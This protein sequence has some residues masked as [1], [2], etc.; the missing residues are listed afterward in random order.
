MTHQHSKGLTLY[1]IVVIQNSRQLFSIQVIQ[2]MNTMKNE[3]TQQRELI[4]LLQSD[5]N[6]AV[7]ALQNN[8]VDVTRLFAD[9]DN[10]DDGDVPVKGLLGL[11][12][13]PCNQNR[14]LDL[15]NSSSMIAKILVAYTV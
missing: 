8:G 10:D 1:S 7:L 12:D 13:W 14:F 5:K 4:K 3:N 15:G 9:F 2:E 11:I 6:R